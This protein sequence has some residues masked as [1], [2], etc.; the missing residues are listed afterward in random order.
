MSTQIKLQTKLPKDLI[1]TTSFKTL[2]TGSTWVKHERA[3]GQ[4][5]LSQSGTQKL[6]EKLFHLFTKRRCPA[7]TGTQC[8]AANLT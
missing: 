1:R 8:S 7:G 4:K 2:T 3:E 6:K 5:V